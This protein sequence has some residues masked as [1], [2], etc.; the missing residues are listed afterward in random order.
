MS[1][2][3]PKNQRNFLR[4]SALASNFIDKMQFV[5]SQHLVA[6]LLRIN[7]TITTLLKL[8][9]L[10]LILHNKIELIEKLA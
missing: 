6:D 2:F 5:N 3:G 1:S 9:L 8:P 4:I 10:V 7:C